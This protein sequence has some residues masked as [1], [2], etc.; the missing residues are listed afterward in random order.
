MCSS[1]L[2]VGDTA[3]TQM[4]DYLE[5]GNEARMNLPSTLGINWM[6]RMEKDDID[7]ILASKIFQLTKLYGRCKVEEKEDEQDESEQAGTENSDSE[8]LQG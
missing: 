6:W 3:I 4:Q 8:I 1:D 7:P 5:L 2:S